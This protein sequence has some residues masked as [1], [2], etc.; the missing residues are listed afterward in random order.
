MQTAVTRPFWFS[1][2]FCDEFTWRHQWGFLFN[3]F[4]V[5]IS[6]A[7][8][9]FNLISVIKLRGLF[10]YTIIALISISSLLQYFNSISNLLQYFNSMLFHSEYHLFLQ[11][12]NHTT[13]GKVNCFPMFYYYE[14][15]LPLSVIVMLYC[16]W[17]DSSLFACLGVLYLSDLEMHR[18]KKIELEKSWYLQ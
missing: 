18:G 12:T 7:D 11:P 4:L 16:L 17:S 10:Q 1:V 9:C 2:T 13:W 6:K 8:P 14:I 3:I 15:A 5:K